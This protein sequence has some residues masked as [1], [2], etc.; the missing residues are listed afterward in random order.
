M[1]PILHTILSIAL[2]FLIWC[3]YTT[4]ISGLKCLR[5]FFR[6]KRNLNKDA[7]DRLCA[8]LK[9][10]S[11]VLVEMQEQ[12]T[13]NVL[14]RDD[15]VQ[16]ATVQGIPEK[17]NIHHRIVRVGGDHPVDY[18][19]NSKTKEWAPLFRSITL[20]RGA[21]V[22]A[23]RDIE[24]LSIRTRIPGQRICIPKEYKIYEI[25]EDGDAI[26]LPTSDDILSPTKEGSNNG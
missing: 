5:D 17:E 8:L 14:N 15:S 23:L 9:G 26:L 1:N 22:I 20:G 13:V 12:A 16:Y 11:D 6:R 7:C 3:V 25:A 18:M 21:P 4:S 2:A 10:C 24:D 19:Y